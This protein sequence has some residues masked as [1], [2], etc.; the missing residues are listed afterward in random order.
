MRK[1]Y[2]ASDVTVVPSMC[3]NLPTV[4]MESLSCGTPVAAFDIG[5]NSDMV[6][7]KKNGYLSDPYDTKQLAEGI[8]F[9]LNNNVIGELSAAARKKVLDCFRIQDVADQY[10]NLY[11]SILNT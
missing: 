8:S 9:C 1:A 10:V 5:G 7:H 3:E 11:K 2:S 4:I 6:D